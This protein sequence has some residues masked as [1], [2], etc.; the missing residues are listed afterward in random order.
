[1]SRFIESIKL[2]NGEF[3]R[4]NYHQQR[5][6][7]TFRSFFPQAAIPKLNLY[8]QQLDVPLLGLYKCRVVYDVDIQFVEFVPYTLRK[9]NTLKLVD[10]DIETTQFKH[11]NRNNYNIAFSQRENCD[12]VLLIRNQIITDTSYCNVA[13]YNGYKW[14]TPKTPLLFG[15]QRA[16]LLE[17]KII[18]EME[19]SVSEL[20]NFEKVRLFNAMIEFGELEISTNSIIS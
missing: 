10:T 15:T 11:E 14:L 8:F 9:I 17:N 6:E 13:F 7:N 19:I 4:L 5:L 12:D 20:K 1:M 3:I 16:F 18:S 2:H